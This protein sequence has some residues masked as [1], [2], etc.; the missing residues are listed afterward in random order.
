MGIEHL[1]GSME[2]VACPLCGADDDELRWEKDG[3]RVV[4]CRA[5]SLVYVNPR[6]TMEALAG[7][8]NDQVISYAHYYVKT[9][10]VDARSFAKR[11]DLIERQLGGPDRRGR[12]L[13]LGCGPGTFMKVAAE[14]GWQVQGI[15]VNAEAVAHCHEAGLDVVCGTFPHEHF[16]GQTYELAVMSDFIEHVTDPVGVLREVRELLVPGGL[17]FIT[18]PDVGSPLA[19]AAGERWPHLK[20]V[21][22][23]TYFSRDTARDLLE[24]A[25]YRVEVLRSMGR[26]RNL[27]LALERLEHFSWR[28]SRLSRALVPKALAE[29]VNVP[30]NP[31]DE[32]AILASRVD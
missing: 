13:E 20:P 5:C 32:M 11:L 9:A 30:L 7:L 21:E 8:Y 28:L 19:R 2:R 17:V 27:G 26:V 18:T 31:G 16:A 25:G 22:H 6:L 3:F 15:D 10:A 12:L 23:L 24:R 29:N 4:S 1:E 14:R